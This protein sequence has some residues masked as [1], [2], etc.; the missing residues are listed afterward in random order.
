MEVKANTTGAWLKKWGLWILLGL[1]V[2]LVVL[3]KILPSNKGGKP[4]I[5]ADAKKK[6]D[7]VKASVSAELKAHNEKMDA[8]K[9]ELDRIKAIADEDERLKALAD[10]AN[11]RG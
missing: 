1:V 4:E 3:S 7:E 2:V 6:L 5:L 8:N 9:K 11:S 10:F